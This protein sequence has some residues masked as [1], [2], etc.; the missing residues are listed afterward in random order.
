[1]NEL[2]VSLLNFS[3]GNQPVLKE[4]SLSVEKGKFYS[5]L[6]PNG[7]GKTTILRHIQKLLQPQS[8]KVLLGQEEVRLLNFRELAKK[9]AVVPQETMISVDFSVLDFVLSGRAPFLG[10]FEN[11]SP[12]DYKKAK[13]AMIATNTM[14][15]SHKSVKALSGG[16]LQRVVVARAMVQE[17]ELLLLDEPVSHLDLRHQVLVL[18]QVS[19]YCRK[20]RNTVISV[21]HD[22]NLAI[23]Y[24]DE[25][26]LMKKGEIYAVGKPEEVITEQNLREVYET[27]CLIIQNPLDGKPYV[28]PKIDRRREEE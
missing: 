19:S 9:I 22:I 20:N 17:P 5:I 18:D 10:R 4:L 11:E 21:L 6:G 14:Q 3:Y 27:E 28:I 26:V 16:E 24:S 12:S 7:S 13:E 2:T 25:L 8:G 1:M 15:Y 23:T